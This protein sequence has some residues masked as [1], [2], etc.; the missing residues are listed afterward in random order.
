MS[1]LAFGIFHNFGTFLAF[2]YETLA[3]LFEDSII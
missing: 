1:I 3:A 2:F